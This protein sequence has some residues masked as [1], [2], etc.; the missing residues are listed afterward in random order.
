[1]LIFKAIRDSVSATFNSLTIKML[2]N[3]V[4]VT[5]HRFKR[6]LKSRNSRV[7]AVRSSRSEMHSS[8][9][10]SDKCSFTIEG[11]ADNVREEI[12][13]KSYW[14]IR[15]K[16]PRGSLLTCIESTC[17]ALISVVNQYLRLI[18]EESRKIKKHRDKVIRL[19]LRVID[20][21]FIRI[22]CLTI[23]GVRNKLRRQVCVYRNLQDH[24]DSSD[25]ALLI[26]A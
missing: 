25:I 24:D 7:V 5:V 26:V 11:D 16:F 8:E 14:S 2:K 20:I 15:L 9:M 19:A 4:C 21:N 23:V 1:M 12:S 13:Q 22:V 10:H 3:S 6:L 18:P 17:Y